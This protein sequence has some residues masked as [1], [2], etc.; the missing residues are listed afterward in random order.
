MTNSFIKIHFLDNAAQIF[1]TISDLDS[2]NQYN[3][4]VSLSLKKIDLTDSS[5]L[6][7][8]YLFFVNK[9]GILEMNLGIRFNN[10]NILLSHLYENKF[11]EV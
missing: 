6:S 3:F 8:P 2:I 1:Q 9:Y 10:Q 7:S 4:F 11:Q 5:V